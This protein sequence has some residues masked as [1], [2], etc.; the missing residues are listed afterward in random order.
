MKELI[1]MLKKFPEC[2]IGINGFDEIIAT[3]ELDE[4]SLVCSNA[5]RVIE[6]AFDNQSVHVNHPSDDPALESMKKV[7][8][9]EY[10]KI[11]F[12]GDYDEALE[13]ILENVNFG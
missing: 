10:V 9:K 11:M 5:K 7:S 8:G 13:N 2:Q 1:E 4:E 6:M 12:N 3:N